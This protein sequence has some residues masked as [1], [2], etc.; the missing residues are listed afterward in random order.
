MTLDLETSRLVQKICGDV[1]TETCWVDTREGWTLK[2]KMPNGT[3]RNPI[4]AP[5]FGELCRL[6]PL[7]G[8]K[9]GWRR[10]KMDDP[11]EVTLNDVCDDMGRYYMLAPSPQDGMTACVEYL[12][13]LLI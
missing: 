1:E 6:L 5:N 13:K 3:W 9:M 12:K 11:N 10:D 2:P 7:I 4:P 8:E